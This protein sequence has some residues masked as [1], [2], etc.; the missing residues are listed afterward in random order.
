MLIETSDLVAPEDDGAQD[1]LGDG[2]KLYVRVR[3]SSC[4][5]GDCWEGS[6]CNVHLLSGRRY[7]PIRQPSLR[8]ML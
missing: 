6:D 3:S 8:I 2:L 4:Y 5:S 7:R 1:K